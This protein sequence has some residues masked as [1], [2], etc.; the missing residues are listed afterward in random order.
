[1]PAP[2]ALTGSFNYLGKVEF[3]ASY[4]EIQGVDVENLASASITAAIYP[5]S[6]SFSA[7]RVGTFPGTQQIID[8][9]SH[10]FLYNE[11]DGDLNLF[12]QAYNALQTIDPFNS[13]SA[14]T[15]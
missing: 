11:E 1:M 14:I 6:A 5:D 2:I 4:V 10:Q 8:F 9:A 13:M 3:T 7:G 12:D 15:S